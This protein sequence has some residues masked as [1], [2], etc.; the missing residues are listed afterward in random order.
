MMKLMAK[1]NR[2]GFSNESSNSQG[3]TITVEEI[4]K[5]VSPN[6]IN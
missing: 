3:E 4:I 2:E 1:L 5:K 6:L